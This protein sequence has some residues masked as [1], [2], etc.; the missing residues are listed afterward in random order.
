MFYAS[1]LQA[2]NLC[3]ALD[4]G[5][6][7]L[8][9]P[10]PIAQSLARREGPAAAT[11][12]DAQSQGVLGTVMGGILLQIIMVIPNIETLHSTIKVLWTA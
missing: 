7:G 3:V 1:Q 8:L 10:E 6:F 12:E 2:E 5:S 4:F 9:N 11:S